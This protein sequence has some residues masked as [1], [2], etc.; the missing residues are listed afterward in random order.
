MSK[1]M[2]RRSIRLA[3]IATSL[4]VIAVSAAACGGSSS[5]D[6]SAAS[7]DAPASVSL[8]LRNDVDSFD[9][10]KSAAESGAKQVF[11]AVYDTLVRV[12]A[13]DAK[14]EV[15]GSLAKSW[16]VEPASAT[17][18]LREGLTCVDGTA[19][20]ATGVAK[21]LQHLADPAT[22]A[23]YASRVFGP[24]GAKNISAD[25][26]ANTVKIDLNA[27][28]T[29]LLEGLSQ[30]YVVCPTA[31]DDVESL[32]TKPAETGAFKVTESKRGEKYV[33]Q[34]RDTPAIPKSELPGTLELRVV[35][36]D[37]TRANLVE[38]KGVDIASILGRDAERLQR[39]NK[40]IAG[41]A[42][43]ADAVLFN[44]VEGHPGA[45]LEV[46]RAIAQ[47]ID[48]AG[49]AK[50]ST[51]DLGSPIDTM[52]T[53]NMA[54]YSADNGKLTPAFDLEA[55]K[56]SLAKAGYGPGGKKLTVR[57]LGIDSQN[58]GPEFLADSL[59]KLGVDVKLSKGTLEQAIGVLFGDGG[60][61]VMVYPYPVPTPVPST[62]VN[63]IS[64]KLGETLNVGSVHND[65]YDS[66]VEKAAGAT[67]DEQCALWSK[68]EAALLEN[69]DLKP[70]VWSNAAWFANDV[71]FEANYFNIDTRSIR[72]T[73]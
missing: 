11:D 3:A 58:S 41:K 19:L 30:A 17:F 20:T 57:L 23:L 18:T 34:S 44:Q 68:A 42:M 59:R 66:T 45:D 9:P 55:A 12:K 62:L 53:P 43:L 25:D 31:L 40:P 14:V 54:C 46:R 47:A 48:S 10:F 71:T 33:L 65:V 60:W 63:Q 29:Y 6:K 69:V 15:E 38:T 36:D 5:D 7:G 32:A 2:S 61:D 50:A 26:A 27:P 64:G 22:G 51:F 24:G 39:S 1:S 21:S 67:G 52:Y 35:N 13:A 28:Y 37:T 16:D 8:V 4:S 70:V 56:A 72:S 49:Y 73:K